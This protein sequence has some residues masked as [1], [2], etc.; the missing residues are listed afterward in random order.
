MD[1]WNRRSGLLES[2][3]AGFDLL[4]PPPARSYL[5]ITLRKTELILAARFKAQSFEDIRA[6]FEKKEL[7]ALESGAMC[8][9]M[10]KQG[11][12]SDRDGAAIPT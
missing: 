10:S 5:P 1:C 11:Y 3:A 9:M 4:N 8:Y 7:P 12:L 6:A 2:K